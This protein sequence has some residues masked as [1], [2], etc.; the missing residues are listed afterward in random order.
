MLLKPQSECHGLQRRLRG[1]DLACPEYGSTEPDESSSTRQ[2][3]CYQRAAPYAPDMTNTTSFGF[4]ERLREAR[5]AARLTGAELGKGAGES[6]RDASKASVSDWESER[7]YPKADQLR[8]ICLKLNISADHLVFGDIRSELKMIQAEAT[9]EMLSPEQ[10][11]ALL[12]KMIGSVAPGQEEKRKSRTPML[13]ENAN[14]KDLQRVIPQD[15]NSSH[16]DTEA[17][18]NKYDTRAWVT[19]EKDKPSGQRA[20]ASPARPERKRSKGSQ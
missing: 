6:G 15:V 12:A 18:K 7:H 2:Q 9:I 5:K 19:K 8:V 17:Y 1:Q 13:E 20:S 11:G 10:R 4:G 14:S 3:F 16:I